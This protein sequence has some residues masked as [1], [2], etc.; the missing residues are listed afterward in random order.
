MVAIVSK[1]AAE[2]GD[3]ARADAPRFEKVNWR[4]EPHLR[5]LYS[6]TIFLLI[7]AATTGYDG[8]LANVCQQMD[9]FKDY[10]DTVFKWNP[11]IEDYDKDANRLGIMINMFNIGSIISFFLTPPIAD[12][13]GRKPTIMGGCLFMILGS[14]ISAFTNGYGSRFR[15]SCVSRRTCVLTMVQCGWPAD[16][17]LV[18]ATRPRR[19]VRPCFSLRFAT[20]ST[21]VPSPPCTTVSG[22]WVPCVCCPVSSVWRACANGSSVVS[23]IG[24]GTAHINNDWCWRSI[25]LIQ[26]VPSILQICGLWWLPESPRYLV[27]KDKPE[28]AHD[29]LVKHHGGGNPNNAT[30]VF[31]YR[32]IKETIAMEAAADRS[33]RYVDFLLT[34]GNRWRLAI[35][36]SLGV[37]SQY[38]GNALFSNYIDPIYEN[39]GISD[40]NK[41]LGVSL[42]HTCSMCK[43]VATPGLTYMF[44]IVDRRQ[45]RHGPPHFYCRRAHRR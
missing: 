31:E 36:I 10:F 18:S 25:T 37:I 21:V 3:A 23:V 35:I 14:F 29:V 11:E 13:F 22:T 44:G 43:A 12:R 6:M 27:S 20:P 26:A 15:L 7:A 38:S 30:V 39:A 45:D 24:A 16:S 28:K 34:K 19:C 40:Q 32:E 42:S 5:K 4:K 9:L 2:S 1:G 33:S 41:K 17:C 8:S